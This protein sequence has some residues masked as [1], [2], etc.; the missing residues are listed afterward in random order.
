MNM[1]EEFAEQLFD[2]NCNQLQT[3][4]ERVESLF[5][6]LRPL[7]FHGFCVVSMYDPMSDQTH[8][9]MAT[10]GN[11]M[12]QRGLVE[13]ARDFMIGDVNGGGGEIVF[14]I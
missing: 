4:L 13:T 12:I 3:A 11:K 9:G 6:E 1:N 10:V 5:E 2:E 7:G 8:T 14:E